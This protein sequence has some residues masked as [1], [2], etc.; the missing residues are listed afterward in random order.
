[1]EKVS[2]QV[3][4]SCLL[5]RHQKASICWK[6]LNAFLN[7]VIFYFKIEQ[8]YVANHLDDENQVSQF[9]ENLYVMSS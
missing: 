3:F 2:Q 6:G 9:I 1:M 8:F 7:L 4:E 5:Q